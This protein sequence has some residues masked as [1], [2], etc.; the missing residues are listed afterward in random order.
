MQIM[1]LTI[2]LL[3]GCILTVSANSYAQ[4]TKLDVNMSNASIRDLFGY[5]EEK[6]EFV[7]LYRNEDFNVNKKV[8]VNLKDATINQI[9]DEA[10]RGENVTYDVY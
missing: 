10:L 4:K 5:I 6:S 3:F 1:R 7:F 8:A 9:L 2:L